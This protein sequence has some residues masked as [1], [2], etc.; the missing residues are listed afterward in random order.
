MHR[1]K[2]IM[3]WAESPGNERLRFNDDLIVRKA[4]NIR[5]TPLISLSVYAFY[6]VVTSVLNFLMDK[7]NF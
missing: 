5:K 6:V 2:S 7:F 3:E 4:R 1:K